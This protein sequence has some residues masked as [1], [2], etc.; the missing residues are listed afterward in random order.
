LHT[1]EAQHVVLILVAPCRMPA[2]FPSL[3]GPSVA[4]FMSCLKERSVCTVKSWMAAFLF[5]NESPGKMHPG[6]CFDGTI[7]MPTRTPGHSLDIEAWHACVFIRLVPLIVQ[8]M[9][10]GVAPNAKLSFFDNLFE[11]GPGLVFPG[12]CDE[13]GDCEPGSMASL[14]ELH[15][16]DVSVARCVAALVAHASLKMLPA[17]GCDQPVRLNPSGIR[18]IY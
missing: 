17:I 1:F 11:E 16:K 2:G 14:F 13:D 9:C 8:L 4:L 18:H 6:P 5:M 10:S 15:H 7:W 12:S 3:P